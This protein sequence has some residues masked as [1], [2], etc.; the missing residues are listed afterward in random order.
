[1]D[2]NRTA[3]ATTG[4]T[5]L[6]ATLDERQAKAEA[7]LDRFAG[8]TEYRHRSHNP[9]L[10]WLKANPRLEP[11]FMY[12]FFNYWYPVSRHQPQI[13]L[14]IAAAYP[15]WGDRKLIVNNYIEEDGM[16][17][18]GDDPHYVLLEEFI[19]KL[20]GRLNVDPEAEH[21]VASF[22]KSLVGMTAAEATGYVAAIEHPALDISDYFCQITRLA[23]R[24]ELLQSDPYLSIHVEVE[25]NHIIWSHGNALNWMEDVD[26]QAREGYSKDEVIAA[27]QK[28]MSFWNDF[29]A[30]A[31]SK[32]GF[33]S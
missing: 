32:L 24:A 13:L 21:L 29:W 33:V 31:F 25:P 4:Y 12:R 6:P 19:V 20:G 23:G 30:L 3:C 27:Y 17:R 14:R 18:P 26:R 10:N 11:D 9:Y 7:Y 15:D 8:L 5:A 2:A 28:A 16:V 22:H 1:M